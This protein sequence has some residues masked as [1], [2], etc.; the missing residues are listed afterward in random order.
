MVCE[1][2]SDKQTKIQALVKSQSSN[3]QV[4]SDN[5]GDE[6]TNHA[7]IRGNMVWVDATFEGKRYRVSTNKKADK[8]NLAWA[9]RHY[10][11]IITRHIVSKKESEKKDASGDSKLKEFADKRL[12]AYEGRVRFLTHKT[13]VRDFQHWILPDFGDTALKDI[14]PL[15]LDTWQ[16]KLRQRVSNKRINNIRSVFSMI[17]KDAVMD[18]LIKRNPFDSVRKLTN[19]KTEIKPLSLE[20][21][22]RVI[23]VAD[24]HFANVLKLAFFTGMRTGEMIALRWDKIDFEKETIR[25][26]QAIRCGMLNPPKTQTSI[27]TIKMLPHVKEALLNLKQDNDSEWVLPTQNGTM[28][29]EPKT[30]NRRW[31]EALKRA[32]L[33][34]RVFYQTRHT[35]ASLMIAANEDPLWVSSMMGHADATITFKRYAKNLATNKVRAAFLNNLDI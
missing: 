15:A 35:F 4:V 30:L 2:R 31:K 16:N 18:E 3:K 21:V 17:L 11:E 12:E 33:E 19:E 10:I 1:L 5:K 22:Q 23:S 26:D 34:Y 20:E 27:R 32:G 8:H 24:P 25:I 9:N 13:Y 14:R 28:L 7:Y 6:M 29:Y